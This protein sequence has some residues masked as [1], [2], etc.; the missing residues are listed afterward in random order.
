MAAVEY[1]Q[2]N[3]SRKPL[4]VVIESNGE[5]PF[6][7]TEGARYRQKFCQAGIPAYPS[8]P[9]AAQALAHLAAYAEKK[10]RS[11]E[12]LSPPV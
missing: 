10:G 3:R 4:A 2:K 9:L 1:L 12:D 8:L 6:L 5:D 11:G 7:A